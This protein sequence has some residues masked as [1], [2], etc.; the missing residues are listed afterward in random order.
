MYVRKYS[1]LIALI[2]V[3]LLGCRLAGSLPT[4]STSV[5]ATSAPAASAPTPTLGVEIDSSTAE[6]F[7]LA[8]GQA[9]ESPLGV[10][11]RSR[12]ASL[13][14]AQTI[15]IAQAQD[16]TNSVPFHPNVT[17]LS[18]FF[19]LQ[20]T[21]T[22]I[23][24]DADPL[25]LGLSIP[26]GVDSTHLALALL[27]PTRDLDAHPHAQDEEPE[28]GVTILY[29]VDKLMWFLTPGVVEPSTNRFL[30]LL[31]ILPAEGQVIALVSHPDYESPITAPDSVQAEPDAV[32]ELAEAPSPRPVLAFPPRLAFQIEAFPGI[33]IRCVNYTDRDHCLNASAGF[34]QFFETAY[35]DYVT[36]LGFLPPRITQ[37]LESVSSSGGLALGSY[38]IE[39]HNPVEATDPFGCEFDFEDSVEAT[40]TLRGIPIFVPPSLG[41]YKRATK[42]IHICFPEPANPVFDRLN[43][44]GE[45]TLRHEFF[46]AIQ[47][48]YPAFLNNADIRDR[49]FVEGT[50]SAAQD[51]TLGNMVGSNRNRRSVESAF[52]GRPGGADS[53]S[54][55][56]QDFWVYL[57]RAHGLELNYLIP[58]LQAGALKADVDAVL[59]SGGPFPAGY[60]LGTAYWDWA[61]NQFYE[62]TVQYGNGRPGAACSFK[63]NTAEEL[64]VGTDGTF[65][66]EDVQ[67]TLFPLASEGYAFAFTSN[68]D[69]GYAIE[70][71]ADPVGEDNGI[72]AKFYEGG[73]GCTLP[74]ESYETII[75]VPP[76]SMTQTQHLLVSDINVNAFS[77]YAVTFDRHTVQ[78][79]NPIEGQFFVEGELIQFDAEV[80]DTKALDGELLHP[81]TWHLGNLTNPVLAEGR[82][83]QVHLSAG[84]YQLFVSYGGAQ[85]VVQVGVTGATPAATATPTITPDITN[86]PGSGPSATP[87]ITPED[88]ATP[89]STP[90]ATR[91]PT[92]VTDGTI[93]GFVFRDENGNGGFNASDS[94]LTGVTL[95]LAGGGCPSNGL[96][97]AT[98]NGDG[99]FNFTNLAPGT[100]CVR[101]DIGSLPDIGATWVASLPQYQEVTLGAGD[102]ASLV[103]AAQPVF[104]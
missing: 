84:I 79:T 50:A 20:P 3:L 49:D 35:E 87:S 85:D 15:T 41:V 63:F 69:F 5:P 104:E 31:S 46:H 89:T 72:K 7:E 88:T 90:T 76:G 92:T 27:L 51:S 53:Q 1:T 65:T 45:G 24:P 57:A 74:E 55:R 39:L 81:L 100:Y 42:S 101:L 19:V 22:L 98:T 93:T 30:T 60:S 36:Q 67:S 99:N 47:Y 70:I 13:E 29:G 10:F 16:P 14:Q 48:S 9:I 94:A 2:T 78:I 21:E 6:A 91:T 26:E 102:L 32:A 52:M 103:F 62:G 61:K 95:N 54:Y 17:L 8:P 80:F 4:N 86:T 73:A 44:A 75:P 97:T 43:S 56:A 71:S 25:I 59:S 38:V 23:T 68:P 12:P 40:D 18:D 64:R 66:P 11:L 37:A 34:S 82:T 83:A 96:V 77:D 33:N 28:D 58:I